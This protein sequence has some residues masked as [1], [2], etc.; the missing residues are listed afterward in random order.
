MPAP[1][2]RFT[3]RDCESFGGNPTEVLKA[4]SV[5][6]GADAW[7]EL[8]RLSPSL[9]FGY[10]VL[11]VS[12][13]SRRLAELRTVPNEGGGHFML[14]TELQPLIAGPFGWFSLPLS[15]L[16]DF[17]FQPVFVHESWGFFEFIDLTWEGLLE[18]LGSGRV[19][20]LPAQASSNASAYEQRD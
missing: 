8:A 10:Q 7:N 6:T 11:T 16:W 20:N 13:G 3:T 2:L 17:D 1:T 12:E 9:R 15:E 5:R 14:V 4:M 19:G 18:Q